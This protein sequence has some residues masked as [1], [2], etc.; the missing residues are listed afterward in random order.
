MCDEQTRNE[1]DPA[2]FLRLFE[3][4]PDGVRVLEILI[5][6]FGGP[7]WVQGG[8]DAARETLRRVCHREVLDFILNEMARA[9]ATYDPQRA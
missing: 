9:A 3:G 7:P 8:E 1:E 6:T 4:N 2:L 5:A